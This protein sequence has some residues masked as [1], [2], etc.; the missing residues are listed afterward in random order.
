MITILEKRANA[1]KC[2]VSEDDKSCTVKKIIA[3]LATKDI[4]V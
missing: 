3:P 4:F 1:G 2:N